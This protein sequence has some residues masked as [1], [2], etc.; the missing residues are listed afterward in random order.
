[1]TISTWNFPTSIRFGAGAINTLPEVCRE[2]GIQRP[3]V[4]TD[5]GLASIAFVEDILALCNDSGLPSELYA[6]VQ[7]NPVGANV[8]DGVMAFKAG[9]NDGIVAVGGGSAISG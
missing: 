9:D 2:L 1:M 4:I 7:G 3:L 8:D 6:G 5:Q